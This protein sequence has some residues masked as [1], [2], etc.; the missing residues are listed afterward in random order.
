[1]TLP[2]PNPTLETQGPALGYS[3]LA[4][5]DLDG[6]LVHGDTFVPFLM[7]YTVKKRR[8]WPIV[9]MPFWITLYLVR[10]ISA[11]TVKERLLTLFFKGEPRDAIADHARQFTTSWVAPRFRAEVAAKLREHQQA[12]HRVIL[13]S[14]SP[15]I[16][17]PDIGVSLGITEVVCTRVG[18]LGQRCTG[19][20]LGPNCKGEE[21]INLLSQYLGLEGAPGLSYAYGDSKSDLPLLRWVTHGF[22]LRKVDLIAVLKD[23]D[24]QN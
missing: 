6:T 24:A 18:W 3:A 1:M 21:K 7:S 15:D 2:T 22:L 14:A 20:I 17:V 19:K 23:I 12:G 13:L 4:I 9:A 11:R 16:Y 5:F 10:L 8:F